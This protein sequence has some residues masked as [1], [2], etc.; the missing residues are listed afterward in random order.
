MNVRKAEPVALNESINAK[1]GLSSLWNYFH[2]S[3][4]IN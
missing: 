1:A 3:I 2:I 4:I